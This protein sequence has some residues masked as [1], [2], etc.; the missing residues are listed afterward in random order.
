[1]QPGC[2]HRPCTIPK[3]LGK[4]QQAIHRLHSQRKT[5]VSS[6]VQIDAP[7]SREQCK[8]EFLWSLPCRD[9]LA[10]PSSLP[11]LCE[12]QMNLSKG[13]QKYSPSLRPRYILV[14]PIRRPDSLVSIARSSAW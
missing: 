3:P 7:A 5:P 14:P 9:A 8:F 13:T 2:F 10:M 6:L 11:K 4:P 1:L 12:E